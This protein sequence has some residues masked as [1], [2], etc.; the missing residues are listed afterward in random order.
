MIME[1]PSD[2]YWDT[3]DSCSL[4][5]NTLHRLYPS[6]GGRHAVVVYYK[7]ENKW[8]HHLP[9][10]GGTGEGVWHRKDWVEMPEHIKTL[11]EAKA[12]V[13]TLWRLE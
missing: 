3:M 9:F 5:G 13:E 2:Y 1:L 10:G 4:P 8:L 11:E 6:Y 7:R 12:Y